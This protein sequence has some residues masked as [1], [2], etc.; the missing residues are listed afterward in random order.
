LIIKWRDG[1][2]YTLEVG[3]VHVHV[4]DK[5]A[6]EKVSY[7]SLMRLLHGQEI[8]RYEPEW[9]IFYALC[10][11]PQSGHIMG[12]VSKSKIV[13]SHLVALSPGYLCLRLAGKWQAEARISDVD[14][15]S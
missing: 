3:Y 15:F 12:G 9:P 7:T 13:V 10:K 4:F 14:F 11:E 8:N 5:V 1:V 6:V 2:A